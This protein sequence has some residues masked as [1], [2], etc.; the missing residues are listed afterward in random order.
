[1]LIQYACKGH[2]ALPEAM[3]CYN[4]M[5][6]ESSYNASSIEGRMTSSNEPKQCGRCQGKGVIITNTVWGTKATCPVCK[7]TG[8]VRV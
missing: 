6:L 5:S 2:S 8:W 4:A 3:V 7:G 1:M